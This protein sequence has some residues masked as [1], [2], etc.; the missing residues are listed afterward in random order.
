MSNTIGMRKISHIIS[1]PTI[2]TLINI[3]TLNSPI[4][5]GQNSS[6][7]AM[8]ILITRINVD[9]IDCL[10]RINAIDY[11][12]LCYLCFI[13]NCQCVWSEVPGVLDPYSF[14]LECK[15]QCRPC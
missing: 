4:T 10:A 3:G 15:N 1:M 11:F 9:H 6:L 12:I 13:N 7:E 2:F 8:L 5:M 14:H